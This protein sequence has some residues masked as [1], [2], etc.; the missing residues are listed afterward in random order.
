MAGYIQKKLTHSNSQ[1]TSIIHI[2]Y[3]E[4]EVNIM[5][6][7]TTEYRPANLSNSSKKKKKAISQYISYSPSPAKV[8][9]SRDGSPKN[10]AF[11]FS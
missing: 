7:T 8:L 4:N 11:F 9:V 10:L 2:G 6:F 1:G 5:Y 3:R